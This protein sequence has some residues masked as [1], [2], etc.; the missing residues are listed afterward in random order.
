MKYYAEACY[1]KAI[2]QGKGETSGEDDRK[3]PA[4]C[5]VASGK[6][7]RVSDKEYHAIGDKVLEEQ[8]RVQIAKEIREKKKRGRDGLNVDQSDEPPKRSRR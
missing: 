1:E 2:N 3:V 5:K 6:G 4:I 8:N 7:F